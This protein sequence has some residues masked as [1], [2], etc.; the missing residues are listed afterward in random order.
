M[1]LSQR[2][3]A[4]LLELSI[5]SRVSSIAA[6]TSRGFISQD[7]YQQILQ[8]LSKNGADSTIESSAKVASVDAES[9]KWSGEGDL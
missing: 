7:Q 1:I 4:R 3:K 5:E 6:Q 9:L 8:L 2:G